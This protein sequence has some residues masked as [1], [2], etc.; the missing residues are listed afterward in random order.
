MGSVIFVLLYFQYL[1]KYVKLLAYDRNMKKNREIGLRVPRKRHS[2]GYLY[3]VIE[4]TH[5]LPWVM[6][7][8]DHDNLNNARSHVNESLDFAKTKS[9]C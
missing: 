1:C 6:Q 7:G 3:F 8:L 5:W 4:I 9:C 2:V